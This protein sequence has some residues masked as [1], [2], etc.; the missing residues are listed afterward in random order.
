MKAVLLINHGGPEMLRYGEAPDPIAGPG[1]VVVDIHAASVNAADYKVRL[2]EGVTALV[3]S[4][5]SLAETSRASSARSER[6]SRI[7]LS[8]MP[9]SE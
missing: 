3:G 5:I 2:G 6:A 1:E 7:L 4:L 9:C 8:E